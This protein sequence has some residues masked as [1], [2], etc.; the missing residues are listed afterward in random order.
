A[1]TE[2]ER[3]IWI[4]QEQKRLAV[5]YPNKKTVEELD[6]PGKHITRVIMN[7]NQKVVIYLKVRHSW[8]ATFFFIDEVGQELKSINEQYFNLM[9]NLDTYGN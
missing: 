7:I 8:G 3:K 6:Q 1:L 5:S 9:T 4:E 2:E